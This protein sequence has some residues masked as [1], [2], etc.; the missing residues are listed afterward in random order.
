MSIF[1][2]FPSNYFRSGDFEDGS[3][4]LTIES[5]GPEEVG[6]ERQ[7]KPVVRFVGESRGW[8]LN[9]TCAADLADGFGTENEQAWIGGKVELYQERV[10]FGAKRVPAIRC[11][12]VA[13]PDRGGSSEDESQAW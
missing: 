11:K 6:E 1:D 3:K 12:V 5:I 13:K 7:Q 8:V 4:Q 2:Q 10:R 9:K